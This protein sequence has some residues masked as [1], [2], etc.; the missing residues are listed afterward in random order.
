MKKKEELTEDMF[1]NWWLE[2]FHNTNIEGVLEAHPEWRD[3]SKNHSADFYQ[4]YQVTSDQHDEWYEWAINTV[5][6]YYRI[7]RK[8]AEREFAFPYLNVAPMTK[9]ED[10][11]AT[12]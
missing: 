9:E 4:A 8:R 6:K 7:G 5:M 1:V 12:E 11:G 2:R 3:E 10:D